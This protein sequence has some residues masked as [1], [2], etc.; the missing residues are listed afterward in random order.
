MNFNN[1]SRCSWNLTKA[2]LYLNP[3]EVDKARLHMRDL[4]WAITTI[5]TIFVRNE[6]E[7]QSFSP[8][9]TRLP[10]N[11]MLAIVANSLIRFDVS[12]LQSARMERTILR[13]QRHSETWLQNNRIIFSVVV[14]IWSV[15][16]LSHSVFTF[17][18]LCDKIKPFVWCIPVQ[19]VRFL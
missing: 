1:S 2:H 6:S 7:G 11:F 9:I 15:S 10:C 8:L 19:L 5:K 12:P 4:G 18:F 17:E 13:L 16:L 3:R 14:S